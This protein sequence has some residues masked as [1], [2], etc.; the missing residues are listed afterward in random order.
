MTH[1]NR[2]AAFDLCHG[3][4]AGC[5]KCGVG[6]PAQSL[7]LFDNNSAVHLLVG[8]FDPMPV[9]SNL[10]PLVSRTIKALG[11][12]TVHVGR[13][14]PAVLLGRGDRSMVGDLGQDVL[15]PFFVWSTD[16]DHGVAGV[17]PRL[18][19]GDVRD[20]ELAAIRGDGIENLGQNQAIDDMA[21]DFDF[22]DDGI[23][24]IHGSISAG[25]TE[26]AGFS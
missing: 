8:D 19:N 7:W 4:A 22:F 25:R 16:F 1:D 24:G 21:A 12:G 23:L 2:H 18:A 5:R 3:D 10:G 15:H 13:G 20:P 6:R 9:Q 17:V 14:E 26:A 11:E